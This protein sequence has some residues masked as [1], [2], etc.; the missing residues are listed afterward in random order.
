M[1]RKEGMGSK[2]GK[3]DRLFEDSVGIINV[4][5][6]IAS[7]YRKG[8]NIFKIFLQPL[9][10]QQVTLFSLYLPRTLKALMNIC[11][12]TLTLLSAGNYVT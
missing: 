3:K 10:R 4:C 7:R 1:E 11:F 9:Y 8:I 5:I 2:Q 12:L 6:F